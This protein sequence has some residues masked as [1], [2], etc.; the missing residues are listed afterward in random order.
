MLTLKDST[1][2]RQVSWLLICW[3]ANGEHC[4]QS[5]SFGLT[6]EIEKFFESDSRNFCEL[7]GYRSVV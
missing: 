4:V 2:G 1:H 3:M 6:P 7:I 5:V